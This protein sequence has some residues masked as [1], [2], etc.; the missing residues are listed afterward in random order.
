MPIRIEEQEAE[1]LWE[2]PVVMSSTRK[3]A[4]KQVIARAGVLGTV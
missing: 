4:P 1:I 3:Q 2:K